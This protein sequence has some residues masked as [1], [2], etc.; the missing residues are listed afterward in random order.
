LGLVQQLLFSGP[1]MPPMTRSLSA[2][3]LGV[4]LFGGA[5]GSV[6]SLDGTGG[7]G[8]QAGTPGTGGTAG[9]GGHRGGGGTGGQGG[10]TCDEIEAAF[11]QALVAAMSCTL[12][13]DHQCQAMAPIGPLDMC[14]GCAR[15]VNDAT[16][17]NALRAQWEAQQCSQPTLCPAIA[18]VVP[19]DATCV[20]GDGSS[21]ATCQ[22]T[23]LTPAN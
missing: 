2:M 11:E 21:G 20:A 8:G 16:A 19:R 5:C 1:A 7:S 12:G 15:Y 10:Q 14:P 18:C 17:L 13:A 23:A 6:Q 4:A 3:I 9:G 22:A